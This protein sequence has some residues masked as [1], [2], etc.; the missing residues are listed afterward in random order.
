VFVVA[1]LSGMFNAVFRPAVAAWTPALVERPEE[2]TASNAVASTLESVAFFV[3][4]AIGAFLIAATNV[5][6]VFYVNAATFVWSALLVLA[7]RPRESAPDSGG[8]DEDEE[9]GALQ[10]MFAGFAE[11]K[12]SRDLTVVL[13]LSCAQTIVMGGLTVYGVVLAVRVL[14]TGPHGVGYI[15]AVF[16]VGAIVGGFVALARATLNKL[17]ADL[18]LGTFLW[19]MPLLLIVAWPKSAIVF[20]TSAIMGFGNPLVDVNFATVIQRIAP[21]RVLGRVFGAFEGSLIATAAIGAA[22]TPFLIN[23]IGLR[24]TLALLALVVGVPVILL[25]PTVRAMDRRLREP[26]GLA[27]LRNIAIFAPLSPAGLNALARQL[28]RVPVTAGTVIVSE[29]AE[30]DQ[31]YLIESGSVVVRRGVQQIRTE[32]PGEYFGEIGLLRDV[33]RTATVTAAEDSV[34]LTLGRSEFLAAMSGNPESSGVLED[35]VAYR[36]R[37]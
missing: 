11:I 22:V 37:F 23:G 6:T 26:E 36:L 29:G 32:G 5:Q 10:I 14:H 2:L 20:I 28:V 33:P 27:L 7:I 4:P 30:S 34:L 16:G 9:H 13:F 25:I 1:T 31:F 3:G 35:V 18:A 17:A 19:S 15:D 12:R 21:N 24:P 8:D